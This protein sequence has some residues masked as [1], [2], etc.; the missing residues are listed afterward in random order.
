EFLR[1]FELAD[2]RFEIV[3][4]E[5][6]ILDRVLRICRESS[7]HHEIIRERPRVV[8]YIPEAVVLGFILPDIRARPFDYL[9]QL[10]I[11]YPVPYLHPR[12]NIHEHPENGE[13]QDQDQPRYFYGRVPF[14]IYYYQ[15]QDK[16]QKYVYYKD[17][18]HRQM[19]GN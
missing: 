15:C 3:F 19:S 12:E 1:S 8:V 6:E 14:F 7:L 17:C 9:L 4:P 16:S 10:R 13:Q 5:R 18:V 11:Y 2:H